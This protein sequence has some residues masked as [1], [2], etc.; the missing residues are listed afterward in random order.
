MSHT[1]IDFY[2]DKSQKMTEQLAMT[3]TPGVSKQV[4]TLHALAEYLDSAPELQG[5]PYL[6][7]GDVD[8]FFS[9]ISK[10]IREGHLV[11]LTSQSSAAEVDQ[12]NKDEKAGFIQKEPVTVPVE[13]QAA[14]IERINF[15]TPLR[16]MWRLREIFDFLMNTAD[17]IQSGQD[18][19]FKERS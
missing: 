15:P 6:S 8:R 17:R 5:K 4:K 3:S 7:G 16:K 9:L 12:M 11:G 18:N 13:D 1:N 14:I 19:L 2:N 10:Q